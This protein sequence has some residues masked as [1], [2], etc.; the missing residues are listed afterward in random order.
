M[1]YE[2]MS[3]AQEHPS[4]IGSLTEVLDRV[5]LDADQADQ[6]RDGWI[7][8]PVDHPAVVGVVEGLEKRDGVVVDGLVVL[9]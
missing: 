5:L 4:H 6:K 8:V 9:A 2:F 7:P 1:R 3:G